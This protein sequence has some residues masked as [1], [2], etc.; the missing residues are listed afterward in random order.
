M[1]EETMRDLDKA[2]NELEQFCVKTLA[3]VGVMRIQLQL[4]REL[5]K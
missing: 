4:L 5:S 3:E 1:H 2:L